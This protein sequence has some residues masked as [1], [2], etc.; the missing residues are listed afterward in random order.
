MFDTFVVVF[1]FCEKINSRSHRFVVFMIRWQTADIFILIYRLVRRRT[2]GKS[3]EINLILFGFVFGRFAVEIFQ[4]DVGTMFEKKFNR[5]EIA[6]KNGS[7]QRCRQ[8][9]TRLNVRIGTSLE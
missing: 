8:R 2:R 7:M 1:V 4:F 9:G 3:F 6:E 5:L